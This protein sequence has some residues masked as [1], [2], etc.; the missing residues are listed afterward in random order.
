M[1]ERWLIDDSSGRQRSAFSAQK[2]AG[3]RPP[4]CVSSLMAES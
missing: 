1:I 4:R 3:G 2:D